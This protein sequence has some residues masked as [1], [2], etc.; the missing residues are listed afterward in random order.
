MHLLFYALWLQ[1]TVSPPWRFWTYLNHK[2]RVRNIEVSATSLVLGLIVFLIAQIVARFVSS[3][4]QRRISA[5]ANLDPGLR[6]TIAR[7]AN[8][9]RSQLVCSLL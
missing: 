2:F 3:L 6:Y 9:S 8:Y 4:L 5:R 7:L 1:E